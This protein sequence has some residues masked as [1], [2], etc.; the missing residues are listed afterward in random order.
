MLPML[1]AQHVLGDEELALL[2]EQLVPLVPVYTD[3]KLTPLHIACQQQREDLVR[4]LAARVPRG[5]L[6][7]VAGG[8]AGTPLHVARRLHDVRVARALVGF[9][10]NV[11]AKDAAARTPLVAACRE[12]DSAMA[13]EL[14]AL[15][16]DVAAADE[17]GLTPL[18]VACAA[19]HVAVAEVLIQRG[20][21]DVDAIDKKRMSALHYVA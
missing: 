8:E 16:A 13:G 12:G 1:M 11:D 6:D 18:H 9:G 17:T 21:A 7:T 15:G 19:G 10:A 14:L 20:R 2:L 4:V 3:A 5:T